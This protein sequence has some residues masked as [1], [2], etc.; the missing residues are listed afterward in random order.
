MSRRIPHSVDYQHPVTRVHAALTS[1]RY[2]RDRLAQAG[3]DHAHVDRIDVGAG[4]IAVEMT[5][6]IPAEHL[7]SIVTKIRPGDLT[8]TRTED[9]GALD[10]ERAS[11]TFTA[12]VAGMPGE[13]SGA[14][15]LTATATGATV[16]LD[17]QV[18]VSIPLIG[19]KIESVIAEQ[20]IELFGHEDEFTARWL[21]ANEH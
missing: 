12:H 13:L 5:Q 3:G 19:S 17:G 15:T 14:L 21:S 11:G 2:W 1:E 16:T 4:T 6:A 18:Q 20:V 7:P 10:G 9:W 8:I